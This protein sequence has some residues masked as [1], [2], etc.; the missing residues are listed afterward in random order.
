MNSTGCQYTMLQPF[1]AVLA[2]VLGIQAVPTGT[3]QASQATC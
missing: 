2:G 1:A 3:G